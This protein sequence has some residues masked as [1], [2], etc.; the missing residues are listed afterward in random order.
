M[1]EAASNAGM[2]RAERTGRARVQELLARCIA[3]ER[4]ADDDWAYEDRGFL[5]R[6]IADGTLAKTRVG[7]DWILFWC[8]ETALRPL[9]RGKTRIVESY[10]DEVIF[11]GLPGGPDDGSGPRNWELHEG[12]LVA[13]TI[14]GTFRLLQQDNGRG[15]LLFVRDDRAPIFLGTG[16]I[17]TLQRTADERLLQHDGDPLRVWLFGQRLEFHG[18]GVFGVVAQ[19]AFVGDSWLALVQVEDD[20][21]DLYIMSRRAVGDRV[22]S[23]TAADLYAGNLGALG[24]QPPPR[25]GKFAPPTDETDMRPHQPPHFNRTPATQS[26]Q[27]EKRVTLPSRD[28]L[29][30]IARCLSPDKFPRGN[31]ASA[32][33]AVYEAFRVLNAKGFENQL[34]STQDIYDLCVER[35][36]VCIPGCM[37]TF[38]RALEK[39]MQATRLGERNGRRWWVRFGDLRRADSKL[40]AWIRETF[41]PLPDPVEETP[42]PTPSSSSPSATASTRSDVSPV[43]AEPPSSG[44][45]VQEATTEPS[46]SAIPEATSSGSEAPAPSAQA[47]RLKEAAHAPDEP[48]EDDD[49]RLV[50]YRDGRPTVL[51]SIRSHVGSSQGPSRYNGKDR[52]RGPPRR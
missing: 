20:R 39:F 37:K 10:A 28:D 33:A 24:R 51:Q 34:L 12:A 31:G 17:E 43:K 8:T 2:S 32:L 30:R 29:R 9:V 6:Q 19:A 35:A 27:T 46:M 11:F 1:L 7:D 13:T 42:T 4:R 3:R 52:S 21:F 15:T 36:K 38:T 40:M 16:D 47:A 25:T 48:A 14:G 41:D 18:L 44:A 22:G 49:W 50:E 45:P 26:P 5:Y 23:Y